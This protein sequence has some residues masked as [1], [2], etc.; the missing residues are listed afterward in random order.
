MRGGTVL[1][2]SANT[3]DF[4]EIIAE[5]F[6]ANANYVEG[7]LNRFRSDPSLVDESWRTYFSELLGDRADGNG[8]SVSE[9]SN[10]A[11]V[12]EPVTSV[13]KQQAKSATA[14]AAAPAVSEVNINAVPIR[15]AALKI[16]ENMEQSLT[17]PT[18]TS[19]RQIPIKVLE[20]NRR[21]INKYLQE[22]N[23]GK[24]SFTHVIAWAIVKALKDFPQLNDGFSEV[25][26]SPV[27][28][29]REEVNLGLAIDQQ[30]KDGSRSLLVPNIK[31]ANKMDFAQFLAAYDDVVKRARTGKLGVPDFQGTTVSLTNPGTLGTVSST[32]RLMS[33]QSVIIATG[34]IEYPAEYHAMAPEAL[35]E[36]GISK[37]LTIS[38]TYDHRIIQGAESGAF[39]A[40]VHELLLGKDSF[41]DQI[42]LDLGISYSP[43]RW[44]ID[45]NPAIFGRD[46]VREQT[47][48]QARVLEL[49]NAYRVRGH[50]IADID[51][52]HAMPIIRHPEL[53]L[54]TYGLTIWDLDREF[55]T[56]GLGGKEAAPLREILDILQR[57]YCG[58]VGTE[59]RHIQSKEQKVWLREQIRQEFV[60]PKPLSAETKRELLSKIIAAEQ[61][62]RFRAWTK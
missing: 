35:S 34:A 39:L 31:G 10:G 21:I 30:K 57:A 37:T 3:S 59:Y 15:G 41:Y 52:L 29:K 17:V 5:H 11:V 48:K 62:E 61:F 36:L 38:S 43:M 8:H 55:I 46:H 27:R 4:S 51:P 53:D 50:L 42:F 47:T 2:T 25:S 49:I 12:V 58:K 24:T 22:N 16:V 32:P 1:S 33:G 14:A 6:G 40:R 23:K 60:D 54:E 28:I 9:G 56:G 45:R 19:V 20:E 7:L 44:S 13:P 18:A 26:G